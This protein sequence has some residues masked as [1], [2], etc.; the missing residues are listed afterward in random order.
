MFSQIN[1]EILVYKHLLKPSMQLT[2]FKYE[3]HHKKTSV[4]THSIGLM[5]TWA[6]SINYHEK[7]HS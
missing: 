4:I 2:A 6:F 1:F 7:N 3:P 5:E